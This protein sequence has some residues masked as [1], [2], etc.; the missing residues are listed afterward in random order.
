MI[1]PGPLLDRPPMLEGRTYK[2]KP[3]GEEH[4]LYVTINNVRLERAEEPDEVRPFEI[5][6]N[7]KSMEHFQWI[8]A[9]TRITSAVFRKGGDVNFLVEEYR[10]VFDPRGGRLGPDGYVPSLVAEIGLVLERHLRETCG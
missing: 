7:C 9:L 3:P 1:P 5:F 4:A 10:S 2:V 8:I 6:V